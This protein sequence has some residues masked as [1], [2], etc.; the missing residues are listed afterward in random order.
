MNASV[1]QNAP[2]PTPRREKMNVSSSVGRCDFQKST[3]TEKT[4][5]KVKVKINLD[6]FYEFLYSW[7]NYLLYN[8]SI[9]C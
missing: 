1:Q 6:Q 3:Y 2:V 8:Y 7:Y 9:I 5:I 4:H